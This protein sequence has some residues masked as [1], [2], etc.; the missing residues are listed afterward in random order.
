MT[1]SGSYERTDIAFDADGQT[2]RGWLFRPQRVSGPTPLVVLGGGFSCVKEMGLPAFAERFAAAG[3]AALVFD[4]RNLGASDGSPRQE[5]DPWQQVEDLRHALTFASTLPGIDPQR[6]GI[7]G[8]SYSGGHCLVVGATDRRVKCVVAQMPTISGHWSG[9]RRVPMERIDELTATFAADRVRRMQGAAPIMRPIAGRPDEQ[10]IYA[11]PE[12]RAFFEREAR[13][14]PDWRN[15]VTLRSMEY[16]RAYEPGAWIEFISPTPLLMI[17]GRQDT[18]TCHDLQLAAFERA[19]EPKRLVLLRGGHFACYDE[20]FE[21]A[22]AA[23]LEW[24][25]GHLH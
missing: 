2:V 25:R 18:L 7:W 10:P 20:E 22:V 5:L 13:A 19:L 3:L 17:V 24:F 15:E 8:T 4:Y 1:A 14:A 21:P 16:A 6:L 9:L 11:T 12:V 23:A